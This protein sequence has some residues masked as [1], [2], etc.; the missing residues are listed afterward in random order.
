MNNIQL[1]LVGIP[2]GIVVVCY[3]FVANYLNQWCACAPPNIENYCSCTPF[4][5]TFPT[6]GGIIIIASLVVWAWLFTNK[7]HNTKAKEPV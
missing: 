7:R 5:W 3:G 1:S 2:I 6:I 4:D